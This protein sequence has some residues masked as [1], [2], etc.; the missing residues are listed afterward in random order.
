MFTE[1]RKPLI[2]A[3]IV[4][5]DDFERIASLTGDAVDL[6]EL[7]IDLLPK[8]P[9]KLLPLVRKITV[10]KIVTVRDP[11]EGG[12]NGLSEE[13]RLELFRQWLPE[14]ES[15][16][17]ELKN[18]LKFE[19]LARDAE[20]GGKEVIFSFHD[21]SKTPSFEELRAMMD[22]SAIIPNRIFK[23]ATAVKSWRDIEVLIHLI[24]VC[25]ES[26]VAAMG[27]GALGKLSRLVLARAGSYL[28]YGSLGNAVIPGQW[29]VYRLRS[30]FE[31]IFD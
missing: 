14:C 2:V 7:R 13:S 24:E 28:S 20:L 4:V 17:I 1:V 8:E 22:D 15:I 10:P 6:C 16:D 9:A 27:M 30:L 21:F 18:A 12:A 19:E 26:R 3:V 31:E 5:L 25:S 23:I 11:G 29:P